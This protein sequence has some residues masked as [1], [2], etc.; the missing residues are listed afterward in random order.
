MTGGRG[1]LLGQIGMAAFISCPLGV[2][3]KL[4]NANK[5]GGVCHCNA[6]PRIGRGAEMIINVLQCRTI[7]SRMTE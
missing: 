5:G 2:V 4:C 6:L 1:S 3:Q 7:Q